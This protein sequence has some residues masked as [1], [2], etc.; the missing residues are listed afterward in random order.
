MVGSRGEILVSRRGGGEERVRADLM[1]GVAARLLDGR[2]YTVQQW[3][4]E[5]YDDVGVLVRGAAFVGLADPLVAAVG[6]IVA[7]S[8][9][10]HM[11]SAPLGQAEVRVVIPDEQLGLALQWGADDA[12][13]GVDCRVEVRR[14]VRHRY[15]CGPATMTIW[16]R[17]V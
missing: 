13:S 10:L 11:S 4:W 1:D 17:T 3:L 15:R 6:E 2:A 12:Q 7:D 9:M 8:R 14:F 16:E 5:D